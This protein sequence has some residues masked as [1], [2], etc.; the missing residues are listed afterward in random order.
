[1]AKA[2]KL[3]SGNWRARVY[4]HTTPDGKK[5]YQSF[6]ASTKQEAEMLAAKFS[7]NRPSAFVFDLTVDAAINKYI[8]SKTGV[9]SPSTIRGYRQM[10]GKYY[11]SIAKMK[12][13]KLTS[14]D[15]QY[16]ISSISTKLSPKTTR[17]VYGLL[18]ASIAL[19]APD[20]RFNVTLPMKTTNLNESP[21]ESQIMELYHGAEEWLQKCIALGAF[22][23]LRRGEIAALKYKDIRG[24][25]VY[26]HSDYVLDE[27][28]QWIYKE[29]PKTVKSVRETKLPLE[30]VKLLGTGKPN[31]FV[32]GVMPDKI[33]KGF[34]RLKKKYGIEI[35]FHDTR[36]FYASICAV[37]GI[38]DIV[39][40][41][42]GGWEHDS[43]IFKRTYQGN[44]RSISD[45]YSNHLN[46]HFDDLMRNAE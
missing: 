39:A 6:T 4:S 12:V 46:N 17:N 9:L 28:K 19:F 44:I 15:L 31:D 30:V 5:H 33:T 3:P 37:L 23:G 40:A 25:Y 16:F 24:Q 41:D 45:G 21:S 34:Y 43:K 13:K 38:P 10:Q 20:M 1:M 32:I 29:M 7:N 36:H 27:N 11:D 22:G 35:S 42:F 8:E 14:A 26:I 2:K 18:T